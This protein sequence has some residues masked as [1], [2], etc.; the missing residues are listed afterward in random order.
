MEEDQ[1]GPS[2]GPD[3]LRRV[4]SW[5][6]VRSPA[7]QSHGRNLQAIPWPGPRRRSRDTP[8]PTLQGWGRASAYKYAQYKASFA[9]DMS[10]FLPSPSLPLPSP[11]PQILPGILSP[12]LLSL[13]WIVPSNGF[14]HFCLSFTKLSHSGSLRHGPPSAPPSSDRRGMPPR[15]TL[16]KAGLA[17][18]RLEYRPILRMILPS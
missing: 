12:M 18:G 1:G 15:K 9:S 4:H 10:S 2:A 14:S 11:F 5:H 8:R 13:Y 3:W 16:R 6:L 17:Y 7:R